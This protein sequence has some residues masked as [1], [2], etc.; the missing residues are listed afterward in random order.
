LPSMD[1]KIKYTAT[2]YDASMHDPERLALD[3][4]Q[5]GRAAHPGAVALNY[6]EAIG[7]DGEQITLRD[8]ESGTEF[9]VTADVVVNASGP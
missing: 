6:V 7:R 2:Y 9:T 4:L 5:D 3:V 8:R 1:P